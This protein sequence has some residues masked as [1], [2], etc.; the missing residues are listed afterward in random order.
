MEEDGVKHKCTYVDCGKMFKHRH[1]LLRHQNQNHGRMPRARMYM[2][3]Q[4]M[5][6]HSD[7]ILPMSVNMVEATQKAVTSAMG[8]GAGG[9]MVTETNGNTASSPVKIVPMS[10]DHSEHDNLPLVDESS[11][12]PGP[13][14]GESIDIG[15]IMPLSGKEDEW[16]SNKGDCSSVDQRKEE[17]SRCKGDCSSVDGTGDS[18]EQ[19]EGLTQIVDFKTSFDDGNGDDEGEA[20]V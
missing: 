6:P 4:H 17:G 7:A 5:P 9:T 3:V 12:E 14:E 13:S 20:S 8:W 15:G 18:E 16:G 2:P 1:H 19:Q 10:S 11:I